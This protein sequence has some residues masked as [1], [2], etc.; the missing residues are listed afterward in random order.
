MLPGQKKYR[1]V[2]FMKYSGP[3]NLLSIHVQWLCLEKLR[4]I[5]ERYIFISFLNNQHYLP[6]G[7]VYLLG[8]AQFLQPWKQIGHHYSHFLLH[9]YFHVHLLF[10]TTA[11]NLA[12]QRDDITERTVEWSIAETMNYLAVCAVS[13]RCPVSLRFPQKSNIFCS[14]LWRHCSVPGCFPAQNRNYDTK[15]WKLSVPFVKRLWQIL[16]WLLKIFSLVVKL[17]EFIM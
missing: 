5:K 16:S 3:N 12:L 15:S 9:I 6:M 11:E 10:I 4:H 17:V 1:R 13:H 2:P 8:S 7:C 14:P